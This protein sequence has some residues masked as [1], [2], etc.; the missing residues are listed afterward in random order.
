MDQDASQDAS[1]DAI[2]GDDMRQLTNQN[3]GLIVALVCAAACT[4]GCASEGKPDDGSGGSGGSGG[5]GEVV[6]DNQVAIVDMVDDLDDGD[7][8][9]PETSGRIGAWFIY[10]DG[11]SGG[12]QEPAANTD[13]I[14]ASGGPAGSLFMAQTSGSG[15]TDWGAGMGFDLNNPGDDMGGAGMKSTHDAS[16]YTGVAFLAKG[17]VT[18]RAALF[19]EAVVPVEYGGTCV[20]GTAE[21]EECNDA[22]G[23][24]FALTDEWKQYVVPFDGAAQGGWGQPA[25]FDASML[26]GFQFQ[27][28]SGATFDVQIDEIG[29]Y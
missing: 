13:F 19:V 25:T 8:S 17:N 7:S 28:P 29:F 10:N 1:Q 4:V 15:F 2:K 16:A 23:K 22:H 18:V 27:I 21:G 14:P 26:T 24:D 11:T 5:G 3:M 12:T 20:G 9:I 6:G